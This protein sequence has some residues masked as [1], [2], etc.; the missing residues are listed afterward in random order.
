MSATCSAY[1]PAIVATGTRAGLRRRRAMDITAS[2]SD[3]GGATA[4]SGSSSSAMAALQSG[5][6]ATWSSG[7]CPLYR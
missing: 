2:R 3:G 6:E 7:L 5:H 4:V 1:G